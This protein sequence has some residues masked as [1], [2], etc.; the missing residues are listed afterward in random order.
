MA[1]NK[2]LFEKNANGLTHAV[3]GW[4]VNGQYNNT[5]TEMLSMLVV[6]IS[7]KLP[8]ILWFIYICYIDTLHRS[9]LFYSLTLLHCL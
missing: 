2:D 9:D 8:F 6:H 3:G 7:V 5:P 1:V 4:S